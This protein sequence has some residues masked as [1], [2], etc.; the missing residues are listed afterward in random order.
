MRNQDIPH[1]VIERAESR[2]KDA[3][4]KQRVNL[5]ATRMIAET[6][7]IIEAIGGRVVWDGE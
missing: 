6:T 1:T 4:F 7:E 5:Q 3:G 2:L